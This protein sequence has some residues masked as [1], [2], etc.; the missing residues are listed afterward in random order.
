MHRMGAKRLSP[1]VS[2]IGIYRMLD[3]D[4]GELPFYALG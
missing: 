4:F 3:M 2:W 1:P